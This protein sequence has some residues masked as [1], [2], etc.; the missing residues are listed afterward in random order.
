MSEINEITLEKTT[1]NNKNTILKNNKYTFCYNKNEN[2]GYELDIENM[3][4]RDL[5]IED[6]HIDKCLRFA[7]EAHIKARKYAKELIKPGMTY[8]DLVLNIE[9]SL[10]ESSINAITNYGFET[11]GKSFPIGISKKDVVMHDTCNYFMPR[12]FKD[13]DMVKLDFGFH[14]DGYTVDSAQTFIVGETSVDK[15]TLIEATR[16]ATYTGIAMCGVDTRL[17]EVSEMIYETISSYETEMGDMI[18]PVVGVYG[19]DIG[20]W[21]LHNGKILTSRP[22]PRYQ[23]DMRIEDGDIFAVE[24][25]ATTFKPEER[26]PNSIIVN[27]KNSITHYEFDSSFIKNGKLSITNSKKSWRKMSHDLK[28]FFINA[29]PFPF[30]MHDVMYQGLVKSEKEYHDIVKSLT[31]E[32]IVSPVNAIRTVEGDCSQMEHTIRVTEKGVK[33]YTLGQDY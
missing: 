6:D 33:L 23:G 19:H 32:G 12:S 21:N 27:G 1:D 31:K 25:F 5:E 8:H 11:A 20:R 22:E 7:G 2:T 4:F 18:Y 3:V 30:N 9:N 26:A 14:C 15:N 24:T 28:K 13:G 16:D 17:V 29:A 10:R